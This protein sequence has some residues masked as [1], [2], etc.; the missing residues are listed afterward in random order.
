MP[1]SGTT[2]VE[3]MLASHPRVHGAGERPDLRALIERADRDH[4]APFPQWVAALAPGET[5]SLGRAYC[6]MVVDP[7]GA[8]RVT[9][10]MPANFA[11]AGL[12]R[13]ALPNARII[14]VRRDPADTCVSCFTY[15][16]SGRQGFTYDLRD[17][18]RYYRAYDALMAHWR[19]VLPGDFLLEV[20]YEELVDE[21]AR[22]IEW[23]LSH[24]GLEWD[25]ACLQFHRSERAVRTAS[26]EQVRQPVY[27][28]AIGRWRTYREH[29]SPLF[30]AL[31]PLAPPEA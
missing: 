18:G 22:W 29:L 25:D 16:F 2:L 4:D 1:R 9:D 13:L 5:A 10:K 14:H 30:E 24:C 20:P 8:D 6:R 7:H 21:P 27:R 23:M 19:D 15:L 17:L 12:I 28:S 3:Q 11:Y 31:G 26:A